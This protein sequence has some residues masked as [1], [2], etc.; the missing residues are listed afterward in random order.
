M[1]SFEITKIIGA[2][3]TAGLVASASNFISELVYEP[4]ELETNVYMA[5]TAA[6]EAPKEPSEEASTPE[7]GAPEIGRAHV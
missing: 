2:V 6:E 7:A 5:A 3:L 4:E 1:A